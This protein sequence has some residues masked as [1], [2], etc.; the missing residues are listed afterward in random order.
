MYFIKEIEINK[1]EDTIKVID[2][3]KTYNIGGKQ[4]A[5]DDFWGK[6]EIIVG[7]YADKSL[8]KENDN[9]IFIPY[10]SEYSVKD[11]EDGY[12]Q[13]FLNVS[14]PEYDNV[15]GYIVVVKYATDIKTDG[16]VLFRRYPTEIVVE[17]K[18]GQ[19]LNLYNKKLKV[20]QNKLYFEV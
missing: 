3:L 8:F 18:E 14:T 10:A 12:K 19:Y 16:K 9:V 7:T 4:V 2:G 1:L 17:L 6:T 20:I 5:I 13:L 15:D 11:I